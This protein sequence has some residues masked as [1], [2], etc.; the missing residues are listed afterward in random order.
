[1][2]FE[3]LDRTMRVYETAHDHKVL[4]DLWAES[5]PTEWESIILVIVAR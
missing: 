3:T 4:A 5:G 2:Q 1:M